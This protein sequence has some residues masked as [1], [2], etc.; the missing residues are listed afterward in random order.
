MT[1]FPTLSL[2]R[3]WSAPS[4]GR[5]GWRGAQGPSTSALP[6]RDDGWTASHP[7]VSRHSAAAS[8]VPF[9]ASVRRRLAEFR[10]QGSSSARPADLPGSLGLRDSD[11]GLDSSVVGVL[12]VPLV[13]Q[14]HQP[15]RPR[16]RR[17]G[18]EAELMDDRV[19]LEAV[20]QVDD[21]SVLDGHKL[22]ASGAFHGAHLV[23]TDDRRQ[24]YHV[25]IDPVRHLMRP[26]APARPRQEH[27]N[28]GDMLDGIRDEP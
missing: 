26:P 9:G 20:P 5:R 23:K 4:L 21:V 2:R 14:E 22:D 10:T 19:V 8:P 1:M 13:N 28:V 24:V 6:R 27:P 7:P 12:V 25:T 15:P 18:F 16:P 11:S 3:A 17:T